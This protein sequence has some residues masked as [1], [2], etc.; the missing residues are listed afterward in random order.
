VPGAVAGGLLGGK[1]IPGI[2]HK[3]GMAGRDGYGHGRQFHPALWAGA[4]RYQRGGYAGLRPGEIPAVLH[5]GEMVI[6]K[7]MVGRASGAGAGRIDNSV[8][9]QNRIEIDMGTGFVAGSSD[10]AKQ[11][12]ENIQR[13]I[14]LE[15]VRES[16]PGGLL[17]KV[18]S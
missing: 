13:L 16:R 1:I 3:G 7:S 8:H 10:D 9:Q 5:R 2:L 15:L 17:R 14:Q 12:G 4:P 18:P 11:V 6:P